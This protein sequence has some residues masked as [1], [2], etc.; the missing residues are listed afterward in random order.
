M[1]AAAALLALTAPAHAQSYPSKPVRL[2][3]P[4]PAGG[5][6]D[7][8]SRALAPR[9]AETFGQ[10]VLVENRPGAGTI[11][12]TEAVARA[13]PDGHTLLMMAASFVITPLLRA[14]LPF[15]VERDFVPVTLI[16][17]TPNVLV[18]QPAL[19]I[20]S[21]KDL[22]ALARQR[23]GELTYGSIGPGTPQ[24]LAGEMLRVNAKIDL[25]HVPYQGGA[26]A[27]AAL[28]GGHVSF[29]FVNLAEV[30]PFIESGRMRLLAVATAERV[31]TLKQVPTMTEAGVPGFDST[32][33]FG[34]VAPAAVP[35]E[36]VARW[37]AEVA[38]I[39]KLPEVRDTLSSAG[40]QPLATTPEQFGR[41]LRDET[42]RYATVIRA[43]RV[44]VE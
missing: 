9:A 30:Q 32:S 15:D 17:S 40:L 4:F 19:P 10:P 7:R 1:C 20:R 33:W 14:K 34:M 41:L 21:V 42:A 24:H 11:V 6:L 18:V 35:R 5:V 22:V 37:Q 23:P 27:A 3:V 29:M 28:L 44:T 8:L 2:V 16:A 38:R 31:P 43:A 26:P 12:G 39:V 13:A 36:I 25:V